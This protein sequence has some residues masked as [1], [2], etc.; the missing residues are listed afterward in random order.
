M[1][2][3]A[4]VAEGRPRAVTSA[5][6]EAP[7]KQPVVL[8]FYRGTTVRCL[9]FGSVKL[10]AGNKIAPISTFTNGPAAQRNIVNTVRLKPAF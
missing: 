10:R 8:G 3:A 7:K 9:D 6:A 2:A 1:F 5:A 4:G